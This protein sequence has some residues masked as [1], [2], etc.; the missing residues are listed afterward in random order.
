MIKWNEQWAEAF[1][2]F[3]L[4]LGLILA[5]LF[6]NSYFTY[7]TILLSGFVAGRLYYLKK[8]KEP[9][10]PFVMI[11]TGFLLGF[12]IAEFWLNRFLILIIFVLGLI[13]SYY[14]HLKQILVRFKSKEF[15]K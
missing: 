12:M 6:R 7:I 3:F 9:I 13:G 8:Y 4:F 15:I 2:V 10:L 5:V 11:I 14:L 1:A